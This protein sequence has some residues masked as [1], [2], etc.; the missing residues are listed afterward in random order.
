MNEIALQKGIT[1]L[2][3]GFGDFG[4]FL[5]MFLESSILPIPSEVVIIG[6]GAIGISMLSILVFGSLGATIGAMAGYGLG[7]YAAMPMIL[8]FG[9]FVLVKPHHIY[10]AEAFAKKYGVPG[11]LVGRIVPIIPF[12]VFSIAAGITRVPFVPFVIC[13]L[14]GVLPRIYI[15][16]LFGSVIIKY[17]KPA[18]LILGMVA[19]LLLAIQLTRMIYNRKEK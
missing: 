8:K 13:T 12:K 18:L 14:I 11:V 2:I 1:D 10:K 16:S 3:T 17:H 4:V 9:K 6:A 15:L 19:V 7:R 5:G